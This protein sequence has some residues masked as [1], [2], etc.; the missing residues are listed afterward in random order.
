MGL[1]K[2]RGTPKSP[3]V[4]RSALKF[5]YTSR[6]TTTAPDFCLW[7]PPQLAAAPE[8]QRRAPPWLPGAV[9]SWPPA[10]QWRARE[11]D[12]FMFHPATPPEQTTTSAHR[13]RIAKN[14]SAETVAA[15]EGGARSGAP[16][17]SAPRQR[18]C[19]RWRPAA[20][21]ALQRAGAPPR[22]LRAA[23]DC[24]PEVARRLR[25]CVAQRHTR[26]LAGT[27]APAAPGRAMRDSPEAQC[28]NAPYDCAP[29][30]V[31]CPARSPNQCMTAQGVVAQSDSVRTSTPRL[32][33]SLNSVRLDTRR[34]MI[35][36]R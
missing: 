13:H 27:D 31:N 11:L 17:A 18:R 26:A 10:Q 35:L 14:D 29:S 15:A 22:R 25:E 33:S 1:S 21:A 19:S 28:R 12:Y 23:P 36:T 24:S 20:A 34:T 6:S 3:Y 5:P 30:L 16:V 2:A 32:I 9:Q 7:G 4:P 8:P